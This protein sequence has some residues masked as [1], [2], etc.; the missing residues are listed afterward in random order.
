MNAR[1]FASMFTV[2]L[3]AGSVSSARS[4]TSQ[5]IHVSNVEDLYDEV[6][7]VNNTGATI[8]LD[9]APP[10]VLSPVDPNGTPRPNGGRLELQ[11]DMTLTGH[12]FH[13]EW[14]VIDASQLPASSYQMRG[15]VRT[16][17]GFN[18]IEW[19]TVRN[20]VNGAA[21]IDTGLVSSI[22]PTTAEVRLAHLILTGNQRGIDVRNFADASGRVL[23]VDLAD[24]DA[25]D[26][27]INLGTGIR[28][29][30]NAANGARIEARLHHNNLH[31]NLAGLLVAN[32]NSSDASI[33]IDSEADHFD[34]NRIGVLLLGGNSSNANVASSD[35]NLLSFVTTGSTIRDNTGIFPPS[36][37]SGGLVAIGGLAAQ[38]HGA[39][40][41]ILRARVL[42]TEMAGNQGKDIYAWGARTEGAPV[43]DNHVEITLGGVSR[44][45]S[46]ARVES[47]TNTVTVIRK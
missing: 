11:E 1:Q 10:Y 6:N 20:A 28:I 16:G 46:D 35:R 15:A 37:D 19:L 22:S 45:A 21:G 27:T 44:K 5:V 24:N 36:G 25:A 33:V 41:N 34:E 42:S 13:P 3:L 26:N 29:V 14:A 8:V 39:S 43:T 40:H 38:T 32:L 12:A 9:Q 31:G 47:P 30:N 17:R 23:I 4:S 7:D 18:K 2:V